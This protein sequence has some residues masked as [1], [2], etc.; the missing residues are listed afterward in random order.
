[1]DVI[2]TVLGVVFAEDGQRCDDGRRALG[3][4]ELGHDVPCAATPQLDHV[5]AFPESTHR[6]LLQDSS[7]P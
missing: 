6:R 1:M 2:G 7:T 4:V 5:K 3:V